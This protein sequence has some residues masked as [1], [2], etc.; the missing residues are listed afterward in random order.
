MKLWILS[1]VN[2]LPEDDNPWEP[3]YDKV[4]SFVVRAKNEREARQFA[5]N[6][7]GDENWGFVNFKPPGAI[8]PWLDPK[9]TVCVELTGKGEAGVIIFDRRTAG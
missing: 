8:K 2:N 6:S 5:N 4:F 9:Y 1:P 7:A 3:W